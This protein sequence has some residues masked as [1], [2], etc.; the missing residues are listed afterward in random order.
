MRFCLVCALSVISVSTP[1]R[2]VEPARTL[3]SA[4]THGS[5]RLAATGRPGAKVAV[6]LG[7][8]IVVALQQ[9]IGSRI[10]REGD[11]FAVTTLDDYA[12]RGNL[13]LPKGS[14]GYGVIT[15][16]KGAER[17]HAGGEL[18]FTVT[19]LIA[20]DGTPVNVTTNGAT[21]DADKATEKNGNAL[22]QALICRVCVFAKRGNDILIKSGSKFHVTTSQNGSVPVL[23]AG[24]APA[25]IDAALI[26]RQ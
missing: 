17:F 6:P 8:L 13:V 4:A 24:Q 1:A 5:E 2:S 16:L 12:V 19:R 25:Q 3:I 11:T 26:H 10:S 7:D 23:A 14:P 18:T 9:D 22:A 20:P 15:H 21:A